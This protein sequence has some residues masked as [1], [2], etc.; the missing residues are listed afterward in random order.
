MDFLET[1][2]VNVLSEQDS[3][4]ND[5]FLFSGSSGS[6]SL[7]GSQNADTLMGFAGNDT[8]HALAGNDWL[9][10]D[11][12]PDWLS[13]NLGEDTLYGGDGKDTLYGGKNGDLLTGN[14]GEDWLSGNRGTDTIYGGEDDDLIYGGKDNDLIF[15][16]QGSDTLSGD[17]GSD[18]LSGGLGRDVFILNPASA[19]PD[20]ITDFQPGEDL[21]DFMN[22]SIPSGLILEY[23][24]SGDVAIRLET[25]EETLAVVEN[26]DTDEFDENSFS[27]EAEISFMVISNQS[28]DDTSDSP[29][30][31]GYLLEYIP[32]ENLSYDSNVELW[33]QQMQDLGFVE[34]DVDGF[35]GFQSAIIARQF[36]EA[37][38]LDVDGIVGQETWQLS[39]EVTSDDLNI[40]FDGGNTAYDIAAIINSS[41][42]DYSIRYY[43]EQSIPIILEK[44]Q[45]LGVDD[46]AQVAY[47]L[48]TADHESLLGKYMEELAS[49]AAYEWRTDLGNN[50]PGDGRRFKGRG[51]VQ[52]TGRI[53]YTDWSNRLNLDLVNNVNW[54]SEPDIAATILV[55][56][57]V[58]GTFT[59]AR[60][61]DYIN[62][63]QI[64]FWNA[65]RI[66]NGTDR[67]SKIA[68]DAQRYYDV[69][70]G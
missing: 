41:A 1:D 46:P 40:D 67:A 52:I 36:Q 68:D 43:A 65:R 11:E 69:L 57:M 28:T 30:Y 62:P 21:I 29:S 33:Q 63:Y 14:S 26:V 25:T 50:Q 16:N 23:T 3:Q 66:V 9:T 55:Q 12:G 24:D 45:E 44:V 70:I 20:L 54:V 13:G 8:I 15:G 42:V 5:A 51:Y 18:T 32:G 37:M 38:G 60:L 2:F 47:I 31:P 4:Q 27:D 49:G 53:N 19:T 10:G 6:D 56:G 64:D 35:Y 39:F 22:N 59:G 17:K 34:I 7:L 58:E 48:A 61:S